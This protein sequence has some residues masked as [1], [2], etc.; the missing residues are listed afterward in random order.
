[1]NYLLPGH[2]S[3]ER[4]QLLINEFTKMN[5]EPQKNA[6]IEHYVNGLPVER[7]AARFGIEVSNLVRAQERLEQVASNIEKV[8]ELDWAR[9]GYSSNSN[10]LSDN[11]TVSAS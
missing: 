3:L 11:K 8:K 5:S 10:Q 6:L 1:M 2:E 7:A 4:M 9:F